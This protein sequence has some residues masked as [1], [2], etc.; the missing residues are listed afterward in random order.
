[1]TEVLDRPAPTEDGKVVLDGEFLRTQAKEAVETFLS[2]LLG[3]YAAATGR[4]LA[5]VR[6]RRRAKRAA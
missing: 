2:P 5:T 1:M 6:K 4:R 3:V